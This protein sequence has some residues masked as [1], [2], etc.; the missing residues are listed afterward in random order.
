MNAEQLA[1]VDGM[2]GVVDGGITPGYWGYEAGQSAV[3]DIFGWWVENAL[4]AEY[5]ARAA[6]SGETPHELL[7]RLAAAQPI[8]AHG[9][10]ALDWMNGNRSVLVD[11]ELSG[12]IVGLTLATKPEDVYR[13]LL[14]STAFG[15][16]VIVDA[17]R[18][19][20]LPV[21]E[22]VAAGGLIKNEFLMGVYADVCG[23]PVSIIGSA[24]GPALGSA[25]H[26]AVAAGA[27]PDVAA[28]AKVMGKRGERSYQPDP[29][30][31]AGYEQLY[32]LYVEL[33]DHFGR[34]P[35]LLHTLRR[36]RNEAVAG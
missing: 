20:G 23:L 13:A 10:V 19:A 5:Q 35:Q 34:Q 17:L 11:H 26:A 6:E 2:C 1:E 8:G 21:T 15:T 16:R 4:P 27:H 12:V 32:Q 29:A 28:A 33:H 24:Q 7:T 30:R 18:A 3:G 31:Q 25:I 9:L 14:E 22:I 36:I